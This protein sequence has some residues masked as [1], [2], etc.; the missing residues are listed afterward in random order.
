VSLAYGQPAQRTV[1]VATVGLND[2]QRVL[3]RELIAFGV[4]PIT[5]AVESAA[6]TVIVVPKTTS[7]SPML[8]VDVDLSSNDLSLY[9]ITLQNRS[10]MAIAAIAFRAR[11]GDTNVLSGTRRTKRGLPTLEPGGRQQ[12]TTQAARIDGP[13]GFDRFE[14][15]G[16]LWEDGTLEGDPSLKT[17][18]Q[19]L[20]IGETYQLRRVLAL[21]RRS[22]RQALPRFSRPWRSCR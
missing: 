18:E 3:V 9:Q 22:R 16:V 19:A 7:V 1:H 21:L 4:D 6:P 13:Q 12:F 15:T 2:H 8:E 10:T 11:R 17:T 14:V 20:T 5:L